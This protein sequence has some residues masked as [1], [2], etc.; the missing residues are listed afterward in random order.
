MLRV[1]L[2][3]LLVVGAY[4]NDQKLSQEQEDME[5]ILSLLQESTEYS[6]DWAKHNPPASGSA[7]PPQRYL[8]SFHIYNNIRQHLAKHPQHHS[9]VGMVG[10]RIQ[11]TAGSRQNSADQLIAQ[12]NQ[13]EDEADELEVQADAYEFVGERIEDTM[14]RW[15]EKADRLEDEIE[16]WEDIKEEMLTKKQRNNLERKR[17]LLKRIEEELADRARH[18]DYLFFLSEVRQGQANDLQNQANQKLKEAKKA[19]SSASHLGRLAKR[20]LDLVK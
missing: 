19:Q 14:D 18:A 2:L 20:V 16:K 3:L 8:S 13:L 5:E 7:L 1:G 12:A 15:E 6:F 11:E 4:C 9:M 17:Y 10:N